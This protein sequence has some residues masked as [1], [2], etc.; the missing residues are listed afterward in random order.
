MPFVQ[1]VS[2]KC[3]KQ[4][5]ALAGLNWVGAIILALSL[6]S[7]FAVPQ[8]DFDRRTGTYPAPAHPTFEQSAELA[9][10]KAQLPETTVELDRITGSPAWVASTRSFLSGPDGA[11]DARHITKA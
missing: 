7:A 1:A 5:S 6:P 4:V 11:H 9:R 8:P 10:L 3:R 2:M